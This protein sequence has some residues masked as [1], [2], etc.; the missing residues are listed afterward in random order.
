MLQ[1]PLEERDVVKISVPLQSFLSGLEW[2][3]WPTFLTVAQQCVQK[4][5]DPP[6]PLPKSLDHC[7]ELK[8]HMVITY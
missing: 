1:E 3:E 4:L 8:G 2:T 6:P 5:S 7:W